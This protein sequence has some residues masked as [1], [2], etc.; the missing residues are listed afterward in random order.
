MDMSGV[1]FQFIYHIVNKRKISNRT[2][3]L[4]KITKNNTAKK[5]QILLTKL[6]FFLNSKFN[7]FFMRFDK[8]YM[9]LK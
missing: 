2:N 7:S 3:K 5:I 6:Y 9:S 8:L 1:A 4:A